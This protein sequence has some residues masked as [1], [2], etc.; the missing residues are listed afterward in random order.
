M[1]RDY[2][3]HVTADVSPQ[4]QIGSGTKIWQQCQIRE[5]AVL[6][7]NCN[8]GKGV[9]ID[10]GVIVGDNCKVHNYVCLFEGVTL[11]D[12]VFCGPHSVYTNDRVP[13]AV[14]PD[15]TLKSAADWTI[16][17]TLIRTGAS[18]GA[19]ATIVCGV[20]VGRWA[21][22]AAGA[23]VTR[24]V[25][26]YGLVVG[27]PARLRGFVCP[28]GQHLEKVAETSGRVHMRCPACGQEIGIVAAIWSLLP[29]AQRGGR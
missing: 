11:E 6:G 13:R 7:R 15:G 29:N 14:N 25:P 9:Y 20:T 21:M 28:C 8:L 1:E 22:V 5:G 2:F 24:D 16:T 17:K 19:N 23:V 27:S 26:D 12:G 10:T 3:A 18:I 4:A